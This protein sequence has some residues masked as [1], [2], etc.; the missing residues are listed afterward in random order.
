MNIQNRFNQIPRLGQ[1]RFKTLLDWWSL[2]S[3]PRN[4]L[5]LFGILLISA[6]F[7]SGSAIIVDHKNYNS[8]DTM[9]ASSLEALAK[10]KVFFAHASVGGNIIQGMKTLN[11]Q[12]PEQYP[13]HCESAKDTPANTKPGEFYDY[14]R[15]NPGSDAKMDLFAQYLKNGWHSPAVNVVINKFCFIDPNANFEKYISSMTELERNYENTTLV[16]MTIPIKTET[17]PGNLKRQKFNDA[18]REWV[19]KND[20]VLLDIADIEAW[21][22][23]GK[24]NTF[25]LQG[26]DVQ[27]LRSEYTNDGGHLNSMGQIRGAKGMFTLLAQ[28]AT[29]H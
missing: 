7:A 21:S 24:E 16:Y 28:V 18:L 9:P 29:Q 23:E 4:I 17:D 22:D 1:L 25:S 15:G 6:G 19:Q 20:K 14:N 3:M 11:T 10:M 8:I 12:H 5:S 13:L 27:A 2:L 26:Q